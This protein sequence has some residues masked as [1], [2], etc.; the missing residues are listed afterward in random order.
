[1]KLQV[2]ALKS[3]HWLWLEAGEGR[4]INYKIRPAPRSSQLTATMQWHEGT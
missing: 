3:E 1:M 4:P 2:K